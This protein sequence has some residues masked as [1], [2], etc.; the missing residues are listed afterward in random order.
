MNVM[1]DAGFLEECMS[2]RF[3]KNSRFRIEWR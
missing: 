2:V 1:D 3:S